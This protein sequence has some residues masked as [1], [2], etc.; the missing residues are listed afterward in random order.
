M[1]RCCSR[2][3]LCGHSLQAQNLHE[4][5]LTH[6]GQSAISLRRREGQLA[7]SLA[8]QKRLFSPASKTYEF[9]RIQHFK[10]GLG[11]TLPVGL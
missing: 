1:L 11:Q 7:G 10:E 5:E 6:R 2:N 4:A 8:G 3:P 9:W